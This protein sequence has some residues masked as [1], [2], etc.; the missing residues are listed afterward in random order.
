MLALHPA[1]ATTA[2]LARLYKEIPGLTLL[3]DPSLG[4]ARLRSL[5]YRR[6][7][8]EMILLLGHGNDR[9]LFARVD[10]G[11]RLLLDH[12]HVYC[13]RQHPLVGIWCH[14]D[15]FARREGLHGLFTGMFISELEEAQA[16]GIHTDRDELDL[17]NCRFAGRLRFLLNAGIPFPKIV[18]YLREMDH[19]RSELTL[20]N[21]GN[22]TAL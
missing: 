9:G 15:E 6:P 19:A 2:F 7:P 21:Y 3:S 20:F 17:E 10:D 11:F 13:L 8:G 4:R 12:S 22:L 14:A 1:D 18:S 5:L 16:W